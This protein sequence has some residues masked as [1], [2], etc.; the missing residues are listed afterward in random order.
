MEIRGDGA[1]ITL[2]DA[3]GGTDFFTDLV[4]NFYAG[5]ERDALLRPM[6]PRD[7]AGPRQRLLGFLIQYWGGPTTYSDERGHPRLRMRHAPFTV[8]RAARDRWMDLMT[9]A[10]DEIAFPEPARAAALQFLGGV[11][12]FLINRE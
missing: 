11:A 12:T 2:Y 7:L 1:A 10:C 5:V 9:A 8:D 6:Y 3:V 4:D